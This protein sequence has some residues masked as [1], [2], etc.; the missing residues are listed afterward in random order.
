M[1][2]PLRADCDAVI[3]SG[4]SKFFGI[5]VEALGIFYYGLMAIGYASFLIYPEIIS[6][7]TS[8]TILILSILAFLFSLYLTYIQAFVLKDWC[9]WC[10]ISSGLS[11]VILLLALYSSPYDLAFLL[12]QYRSLVVIF[13]AVGVAIG[14][15]AATISDFFFFKFL[16]DFKISEFEAEVL[17]TLSQIIW[18]ALAVLIVSGLGLY[19][20]N[21]QE[22]ISSPKFLAKIVVISVLIING[23]I[24]NLMVAP[25]LVKISFHQKHEH[26]SGE[27]RHIRKIAFGLGAV[28]IISWYTALVLGMLKKV[29]MEFLEIFGI[30]AGLIIVGVLISQVLEK[31][32]VTKASRQRII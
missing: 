18:F 17:S 12:G 31:S 29:S 19:L 25:Q 30:Y 11:A 26:I 23:A 2:C 9:F 15:G 21:T 13:H 28:S 4:Y 22:L 16:K 32:F 8:F 14:L 24:L 10:L 27:L 5:P 7:L 20:P 1:I 6:P 3:N